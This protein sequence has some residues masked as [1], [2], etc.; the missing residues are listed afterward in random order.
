MRKSFDKSKKLTYNRR[1]KA[2]KRKRRIKS[3]LIR[4]KNPQAERFFKKSG[5]VFPRE[6]LPRTEL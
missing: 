2:I 4:E 5:A 3:F 1:I 6:P